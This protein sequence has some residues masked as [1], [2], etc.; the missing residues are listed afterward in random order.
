M[1]A[2]KTHLNCILYALAMGF[3]FASSVS[4]Q[5]PSIIVLADEDH[6]S[7]PLG[8]LPFPP[9]KSVA[10]QWDSSACCDGQWSIMTS[11]AKALSGSNSL[12]SIN[13]LVSNGVGA[14]MDAQ[15]RIPVKYR[16]L[17]YATFRLWRY[18]SRVVSSGVV[19]MTISGDPDIGLMWT[20]DGWV[21]ARLGANDNRAIWWQEPGTWAKWQID[22]DFVAKT[23]NIRIFDDPIASFQLAP[24]VLN[25]PWTFILGSNIA[26]TGQADNQFY[27]DNVFVAI[28]PLC[29]PSDGDCNA[30]GIADRCDLDPDQGGNSQDCNSNLVPDECDISS[31]FST[32]NNSNSIPDKCEFIVVNSLADPG[33]PD[34]ELTTLREAITTANSRGGGITITFDP[35]FAGGTIQ[36][37]SQL[38]TI[39]GGNITIDGDMDGDCIPDIELDGTLA[40]NSHGMVIESENNLVHGFVVGGFSKYGVLLNGVNSHSNVVA[41]CYIG[42]NRNGTSA[43]ANLLS[44]VRIQN[45]ALANRIGGLAKC[46]GNL[47]SGNGGRG[48]IVSGV[49]TDDNV[50]AGNLIGTDVGGKNAVANDEGGLAIWSGAGGN[51]VGP[52]NTISGN[53]SFGVWLSSSGTTN[54]LVFENFIGTDLSGQS[55]LANHGGIGIFNGASDQIVTGN[56][57]SGNTTIGVFLGNFGPPCVNNEISHNL[58]GLSADGVADL[59]NGSHGVVVN[60][61]AVGNRIGPGNLISGNSI[62]GIK[63]SGTGTSTNTVHGNLIGTDATGSVAVPNE[64]PGVMITND[65]SSNIIGPGNVISGNNSEGL[66]L[67]N[68][69]HDNSIIGNKCGTDITG[70]FSIQNYWSGILIQ[71]G[72]HNNIIGGLGEGD[73]NL[74]SGNRANG[75]TI[76][77]DGSNF[78]QVLGNYCGTNS[79][80]DAPIP[81]GSTGIRVNGSARDNTIGPGNVLAWNNAHGI[82][83]DGRGTVGNTITENSIFDNVWLGIRLFDLG[84]QELSA[85]QIE[86]ATTNAVSGTTNVADGSV[87]E[88]YSDEFNEGETF[89]G[90]TIVKSGV[91][92]FAG[93]IPTD[94]FV[95][96]TATDLGG[97]TSTFGRSGD[98]PG[99]PLFGVSGGQ[100]LFLSLDPFGDSNIVGDVGFE[101]IRGGFSHRPDGE[102]HLLNE[103]GNLYQIDSRTGMTTLTGNVGYPEVEASAF[104][105]D[106]FLYV[107]VADEIDSQ[108]D[109]DFVSLDSLLR[110]HPNSMSAT[111][112]GEIGADIDAMTFLANGNLV[113]IDAGSGDNGTSFSDVYLI[114]SDTGAGSFAHRLSGFN[115][116]ALAYQNDMLLGLDSRGGLVDLDP[117]TWKG[118]VLTMLEYS[119]RTLAAGT[120]PPLDF[121]DFDHDDRTD[122][123]DFSVFETCLTVSGPGTQPPFQE[124]LDHFDWNDDGDVDLADIA[125]FQ[126]AFNSK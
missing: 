2:K 80:G 98:E 100:G 48:I 103:G 18:V 51:Q 124:C 64:A 97:N 52:S 11:N 31:G 25:N 88:L 1:F 119:A 72:G 13:Q 114:D 104:A 84:N 59:G 107:A 79:I 16:P 81:N 118:N 14:S 113:G 7:T 121:G 94:G 111:V 57:V 40:G 73:G 8:N 78:N 110:I 67:E 6:E 32:D 95:V 47:I 9:Y 82:K 23:L 5:T 125:I 20:N 89:L 30:N 62:F 46:E 17:S 77:D 58:V 112:I 56:I 36:P 65:A 86:I 28:T 10:Y 66:V 68:G 108:G 49:G 39:S 21:W 43:N 99:N 122:L 37:T 116:I 106:G 87:V 105:S 102:L 3:S 85:P 38:P 53:S 41:G 109:D 26:G 115:I 44:G 123:A 35:A 70:S 54:N 33:V 4:G 75:I 22:Y 19:T 50:I 42:T 34:D 69:A 45:E 126:T 91:F 60:N 27:D 12:A 93:V 101:F 74:C 120:P 71:F 96:A 90:S 63:I 61:G 117:T 29:D 15:I 76:R 55:P 92:E 83:V 24:E